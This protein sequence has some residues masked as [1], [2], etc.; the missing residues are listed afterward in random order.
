MMRI[1]YE[2]FAN[3]LIRMDFSHKHFHDIK[4]AA[5][6][7]R[8]RGQTRTVIFQ[9]LEFYLFMLLRTYI[10]ETCAEMVVRSIR[11]THQHSQVIFKKCIYSKIREFDSKIWYV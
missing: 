3:A 11:R 6:W 4:V 2:I 8:G 7:V 9:I 1:F 5:I 10:D